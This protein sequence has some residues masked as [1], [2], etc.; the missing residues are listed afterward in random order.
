LQ[1]GEKVAIIG[2]SGS[3]KTTLL[4]LIGALDLPETGKVFLKEPISPV[5]QKTNWPVSATKSWV[6]FF[7]C[8]T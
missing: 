3:G 2:P 8:T 1:Q 6:L 5:I 7:K 4:N